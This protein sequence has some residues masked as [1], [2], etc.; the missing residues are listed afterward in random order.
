[1]ACNK[2]KYMPSQKRE[3]MSVPLGFRKYNNA[4]TTSKIIK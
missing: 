4:G 3:V 2:N 1:M